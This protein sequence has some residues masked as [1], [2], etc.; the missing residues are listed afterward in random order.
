MKKVLCA[1]LAGLLA[2]SMAACAT[3]GDNPGST[4]ETKTYSRP[5]LG[6]FAPWVLTAE[7]ELTSEKKRDYRYDQNGELT[8]FGDYKAAS[9][10]NDQGGKTVTLTAYDQDGKVSNYLSKFEYIYDSE[11][12]LAAYRR[13]EAPSGKLAD[14]YTFTY[15]A[16]GKV[17][18]QEKFYMEMLQETMEYTYDGELM[19][20]AT[21]KS[22]VYESTYSYTYDETGVP[23]KLDYHTLYVKTGKVDEGVLELKKEEILDG[24]VYRLTL[25]V[26]EESDSAAAGKELMVYEEL[27]DS[28]GGVDAVRLQFNDWG[29]FHIGAVP[30]RQLGAM[31][32]ANWSSGSATLIFKPLAVYRTEENK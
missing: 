19:T 28:V 21:F 30:M 5:D 7:Y 1:V 23:C 32:A 22:T 8:G 15:N 26:S 11:G 13:L 17:V 12:R 29:F 20:K 3:G 16:D 24:S 6:E 9:A 10:E 14:S 31:A 25:C 4:E 27:I 18:K 2:L